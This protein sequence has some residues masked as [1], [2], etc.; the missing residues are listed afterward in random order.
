MMARVRVWW[1][2]WRYRNIT[3]RRQRVQLWWGRRRKVPVRPPPYR[4]R[5]TATP[6]PHPASRRT[7][8]PLVLAVIAVAA[9]A[10]FGDH[11]GLSGSVLRLF[12]ILILLIGG[13]WALRLA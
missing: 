3:Q 4:A 1:L 6:L 5:G 9:L 13:Y 8:F 7:L 2:Y 10:T 12:D 11:T